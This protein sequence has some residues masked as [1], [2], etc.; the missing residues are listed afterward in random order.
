MRSREHG[1]WVSPDCAL[2][3]DGTNAAV[4]AFAERH[5][6]EVKQ[7]IWMNVAAFAF[8]ALS[9]LLA[10]FVS[11][12]FAP[13][14]AVGV[15]LWVLVFLLDAVRS[16]RRPPIAKL[17]SF[18]LSSEPWEAWPCRVESVRRDPKSRKRL[19][20]LMSRDQRA[21][22]A[23][24]VVMPEEAL[25]SVP[26]GMGVLWVCWDLL[27]VSSPDASRVAM[28]TVG[29]A[30]VWEARPASGR[31]ASRSPEPTQAFSRVIGEAS[32]EPLASNL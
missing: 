18:P 10:Y 19:V 16:R 20:Y 23:F 5:L 22:Y 24:R 30:V 9:M 21:L 14:I 1:Y 2:A 17:V 3:A 27:S 29:G 32:A 15:L 13:L 25:R 7:L 31:E 4:E 8:T 11:L 6:A 26:E 12:R 28:S